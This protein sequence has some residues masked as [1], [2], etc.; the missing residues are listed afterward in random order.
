MVSL[1]CSTKM[2][3]HRSIGLPAQTPG[4]Q[5]QRNIKR[6]PKRIIALQKLQRRKGCKFLCLSFEV[7]FNHW[8][9]RKYHI[10]CFVWWRTNLMITLSQYGVHHMT[11]WW[12]QMFWKVYGLW[13]SWSKVSL[14]KYKLYYKKYLIVTPNAKKNTEL[15]LPKV[16][17]HHSHHSCLFFRL[18]F[19]YVVCLL[20]FR[21]E[22]RCLFSIQFHP[23]PG[24][25]VTK[26]KVFVYSHLPREQIHTM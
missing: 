16:R 22:E 7:F 2:L 8:E 6:Q 1:D 3:Q 25:A 18:Y 14:D 9:W 26:W 20:F 11:G 4:G 15:E 19:H 24:A 13:F 23:A 17:T 21:T 5:I 10:D 12:K